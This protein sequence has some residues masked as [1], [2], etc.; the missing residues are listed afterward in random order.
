M[1]HALRTVTVKVDDKLRR[2]MASVSINWSKYIRKAIAERVEREER[3][4]AAVQLLDD[5]QKG[6]H[7]VPKGFINT[8]IRETRKYRSQLM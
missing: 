8:A 2:R 3:R 4:Q 6:R 5:L 1:G 7:R